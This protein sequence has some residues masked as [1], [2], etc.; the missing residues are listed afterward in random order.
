MIEKVME[1]ASGQRR[2]KLWGFEVNENFRVLIYR[3][4]GDE[5]LKIKFRNSTGRCS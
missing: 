4:P 5:R 1:E 2:P 3:F